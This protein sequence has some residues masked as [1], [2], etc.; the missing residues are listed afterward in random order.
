MRAWVCASLLG[1]LAAC[2]TS[3]ISTGGGE[4]SPAPTQ[5][6]QPS[7]P[8]AASSSPSTPR[9]K[10]LAPTSIAVTVTRTDSAH[11][12]RA[13]DGH[14]ELLATAFATGDSELWASADDGE[15]WSRRAELA[16]GDFRCLSVL[17]DGTLL[18]WVSRPTG[19]F[20]DRSDD[21]GAS[22]S[23]VLFLGAYRM[24]QP[25]NVVQLGGTVFFGEYQVFAKI[26]P[27][28][29]WASGDD[30]RTWSVRHV[31]LNRR[32]V[33]GLV[34]DAP[35]GTLWALLGDSTGG[36]L[37][38]TDGGDTFDQVVGS[39]DGVGVDAL[40]TPAGLLFGRD[41]VFA[42]AVP[43]IELVPQSGSPDVIAP[44][45]GPSYSLLRAGGGY[46]MGVTREEDGTVYASGDV[47]AHLFGSPDGSSWQ[48]LLDFPRLSTTGYARANVYWTLPDGE[49]VLDL[50]NVQGLQPTG[51]GFELLQ[52]TTR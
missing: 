11:I 36:L 1:A 19:N 30:G 31:F 52:A 32:H 20:L 15:S 14:G 9:P 44:L 45:P 41:A 22:W 27:V 26:A 42:P 46:L 4:Q 23:D 12:V 16:D 49:A 38:S 28:H 29:L 47:S 35:S 33:H 43:G 25:H 50:S 7:G 2:G 34:A 18:A 37:R 21:D 10:A 5:T 39:P 6:A 13:V 48:P 24:L 51:A 8:G 17:P 3:G 40:V